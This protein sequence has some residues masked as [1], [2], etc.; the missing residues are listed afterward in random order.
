MKEKLYNRYYLI[1]IWLLIFACPNANGQEIPK[2]MSGLKAI[3]ASV[4]QLKDTLP[5]EKLYLQLD[6][7]YYTQ[8]DTLRF[9]CYLLNG[10][11]LTPSVRSGLLYVELDVA[12]GKMAKRI[13]IH[14]ASGIGWG[15]IALTKKEFPEGSYT[16]R[17]Y[18]NWMRNFGEDFVFKKNIYIS[19]LSSSTLIKADFKLDSTAGKNKV[20]AS[21]RF[22]GL[23][24]DPLRLKD[25]ELKVMDGKHNL[26]KNEI[27]TGTAGDAD[28]NFDL[29]D[30]TVMNDLSIKVRQIGKGADTAILTIPVALKRT[31]KT[32]LQF[33][34]EGGNLV[35]G[36]LTKVGFKAI[37]E[38]GRGV[39]IGGKIINSH[40]QQV[41]TFEAAHKGMGSFELT[42]QSGETYTALIGTKKTYPLP[43]INPSGTALRIMTKG[44]DSLEITL[45]ITP[46]LLNKPYTYYLMGQAHG[47]ICYAAQINF[48]QVIEKRTVAKSLFPTGITRFT[49]LNSIHQPLNERIVYIEHDDNLQLNITTNKPAYNLRDSIAI[50]IQVKNK[51]G[52]PVKG[53]FS[54]AVTDNNQVKADSLGSNIINNLLFTSDLKGTVEQ[55]DYYMQPGHGADMDNLLLTQGWVGYEWKQVFD[56]KII[57][58]QYEAES[59]LTVK[60]RITGVF[61]MPMGRIAAALYLKWRGTKE[62]SLSK[63][64]DMPTDKTGYF[65]FKSSNFGF[66]HSATL[67]GNLYHPAVIDTSFTESLKLMIVGIGKGRNTGVE[68]MNE[69]KPPVFTAT[70][71]LPPWYVNSD[72]TLLN[73]IKIAQLKPEVN[74]SS[75]GHLL[76]EVNI[77][78]KKIVKGSR[79]LN[80]PGEADL[81][82]DEKDMQKAGKA[83]LGDLIKQKIRGF[84]IGRFKDVDT[85]RTSYR[86]NEKEIRLVIDGIDVDKIQVMPKGGYERYQIMKQYMD[87]YTAEDITGIELMFNSRVNSTYSN[88]FLTP[89][90][91]NSPDHP[92]AM[93]WAFI[94]VTTRSGSGPY[95]KPNA[96]LYIYKP[97][98]FT[99]PKKFYSPRYTVKNSTVTPGTDMR[100]TIHWEPNIITDDD[101]KATVSFYSADLPA[102]YTIIMEGTDLDGNLGY[103]QQKI[104][105]VA[106]PIHIK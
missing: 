70:V 4:N 71:T 57:K 48:K 38:D 6:K 49:L 93:D 90:Q 80:G 27:T 18:T 94:E 39:P 12:G 3:V 26:I 98:A 54:L 37:S 92:I 10:D 95:F 45:S 86:I 43:V 41:A 44:N 73:N 25:M 103:L 76:K 22:T 68:I 105:P 19:A 21:L 91:R 66:P 69:F 52:N 40:Q 46:D 20:R 62:D 35:A 36:I 55:P 104:K 33:M 47:I 89:A 96:L 72:T 14:L 42:P 78:D 79:N 1:G 58:P 63:I 67:K 100:S 15:D 5:V 97:L 50:N 24:K 16:L 17:A 51:E 34:P 7:P 28:I 2:P 32:D 31:E 85:T 29:P 60:G 23:N 11:F 59:E 61:N 87:N 84:N 65:T 83:T 82:L 77:L 81:L 64:D 30:K 75:V 101:G 9:K 102:D 56:P 106:V 8:N 99:N 74:Y 13:M 53:S 88:K